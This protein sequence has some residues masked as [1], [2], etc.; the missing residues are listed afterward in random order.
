M[1]MLKESDFAIFRTSFES[2]RQ[3]PIALR[4]SII[5]AI[6]MQLVM[7]VVIFAAADPTMRPEYHKVTLLIIQYTFTL[8]LIIYALV[9]LFPSANFKKQHNQLLAGS[10][11][12]L[13]FIGIFPFY[14]GMFLLVRNTEVSES[15]FYSLA[16]V[17][18]VSGI[19]LYAATTYRLRKSIEAGNYRKDSEKFNYEDVVKKDSKILSRL[20]EFIIAGVGIVFIISYLMST[21]PDDLEDIILVLFCFLLFY[22]GIFLFAYSTISVYCKRRFNSFHFDEEGQLYPFGSGD[23]VVDKK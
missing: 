19:L 8:L 21:M 14:A 16:A 20:L 9:Y 3:T 1:N 4:K 7:G 12:L 2:G 13:N 18:V 23:K 22:L 11:L 17:I 15:S 5:I 10:L 6:L